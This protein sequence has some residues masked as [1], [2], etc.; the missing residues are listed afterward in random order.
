[1]YKWK[2]WRSA[3]QFYYTPDQNTLMFPLYKTR[4]KTYQFF[5]FYP[6]YSNEE[7]LFKKKKMIIKPHISYSLGSQPQSCYTAYIARTANY[8][9]ML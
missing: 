5:K 7:L 2:K 8:F 4:Q 6:R 9:L 3:R 1:M